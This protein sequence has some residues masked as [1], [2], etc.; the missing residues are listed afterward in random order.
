[1]VTVRTGDAMS[2][3]KADKDFIA[4]IGQTVSAHVAADV[5]HLFDPATGERIHDA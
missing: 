5:C 2:S 4:E 3:I 1:M